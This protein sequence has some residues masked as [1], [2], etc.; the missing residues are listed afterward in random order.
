M[1]YRI[2]E[3]LR[4][5]STARACIVPVPVAAQSSRSMNSPKTQFNLSCRPYTTS[6]HTLPGAHWFQPLQLQIGTKHREGSPVRPPC[7]LKKPY[8]SH[9]TPRFVALLRPHSYHAPPAPLRA[10]ALRRLRAVSGMEPLLFMV[11]HKV[12]SIHRSGRLPLNCAVNMASSVR[13]R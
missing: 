1:H 11:V 13:T 5:H 12:G 4:C 2:V 10:L 8:S 7:R 3:F 6:D 9:N